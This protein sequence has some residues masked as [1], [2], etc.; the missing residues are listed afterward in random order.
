[1]SEFIEFICE[2]ECLVRVIALDVI[3]HSVF[4]M[5]AVRPEETSKTDPAFQRN[6]WSSIE[7]GIDQLWADEIS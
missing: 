4:E 3:Y 1:V 2:G 6:N 7:S 5:T